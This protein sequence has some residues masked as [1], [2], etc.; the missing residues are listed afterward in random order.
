MKGMWM[1]R[2][3][4]N[5]GVRGQGSGIRDQRENVRMGAKTSGLGLL[6]LRP[7]TPD[8]RPQAPGLPSS[9]SLSRWPSL[10]SR[11]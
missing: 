2:T 3:D 1:E 8:P 4:R 7:S 6:I 10:L 11:W 9:K 5:L